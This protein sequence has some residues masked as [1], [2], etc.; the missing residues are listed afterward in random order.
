MFKLNFIVTDCNTLSESN[1]Y[2]P[3]YLAFVSRSLQPVTLR[4]VSFYGEITF[5]AGV[6]SGYH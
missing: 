6:I 2:G 4:C 5:I 3:Y 1:Y